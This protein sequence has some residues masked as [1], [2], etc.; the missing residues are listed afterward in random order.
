[1]ACVWQPF[2]RHAEGE[3]P[4]PLI[5][6]SPFRCSRCL[7]Y[8]NPHFKTVDTARWQCN[9]CGLTQSRP[10]KFW[11][12]EA[13]P[14]LNYGTYEFV[15][16]QD[17]FRRPAYPPIFFVVIETTTA[18]VEALKLPEV[19]LSSIK[20]LLD[21]FPMK[22]RVGV[23]SFGA[24][25]V[26]YKPSKRGDVIEVV[27]NDVNDPFVPDHPEALSL[28]IT[29]DRELTESFL[30][31]V[32][33]AMLARRS[34]ASLSMA[35]VCTAINSLLAPT[36]G[37]ALIFS[38]LLGSLG[39]DPLRPRD[40]PKLYSTDREKELLVPQTE[41]YRTIGQA[42]AENGVCFDIF[43]LGSS[44]QD[45]ASLSALASLSGGDLLYYY[46][47]SPTDDTER[48]HFAIANIL[49]RP[50]AFAPLMRARCSNQLS[51]D[52]Y[53]GHYTRKGPMEMIAGA[54]DAEKSICVMLSHDGRMTHMVPAFIQCAVL[55]ASLEGR[56]ILR[57]FNGV[58]TPSSD[59]SE[60]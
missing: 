48:M 5:E 35:S 12:P 55:Y 40:D 17:Y 19:V 47:F 33:V 42:A 16:P 31:S 10:E 8:A 15:A 13:S 52:E 56:W 57:V 6:S 11:N 26:F 60:P 7:A 14:E 32:A 51:I 3:D 25:L 58:V 41:R 28:Q 36:G 53:I 24:E 39:I 54:I 4:I 30:D 50:Q 27:V 20:A 37:R 9:I 38:V 43:S 59:I 46:R 1:L 22:S 2:A 23:V 29:D 49:A 45:T 34:P 21:V 44:Y 18:S